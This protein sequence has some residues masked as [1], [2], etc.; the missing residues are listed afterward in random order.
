[1]LQGAATTRREVPARRRDAVGAGL[2]HFG[3]FGTL[4]ARLHG[5]ALTRQGQGHNHTLAAQAIA[6]EPNLVYQYLLH[7]FTP[8]PAETPA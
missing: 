7:A 5:D 2:Q 4:L 8:P 6:L 3:Q 1:M